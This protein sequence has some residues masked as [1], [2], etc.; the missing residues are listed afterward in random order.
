LSDAVGTNL[1]G[2]RICSECPLIQVRILAFCGRRR[3]RSDQV[4]ATQP[5]HP[6]LHNSHHLLPPVIFHHC[7]LGRM[8]LVGPL[9]PCRHGTRTLE[10]C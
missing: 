8:P 6:R 4:E 9:Y 5:L 7:K 3:E 2:R 10:T 1:P